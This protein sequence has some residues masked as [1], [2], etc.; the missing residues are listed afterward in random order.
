MKTSNNDSK[1]QNG[2]KNNSRSKIRSVSTLQILGHIWLSWVHL[3]RLRSARDEKNKTHDPFEISRSRN[4]PETC[5]LG[6]RKV[7]TKLLSY[8]ARG[9]NNSSTLA[10]FASPYHGAHSRHSQKKKKRRR[11]LPAAFRD[12]GKPYMH[13]CVRGPQHTP[14]ARLFYHFAR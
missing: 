1:H 2:H 13:M 9:S 10:W 6:Q 7:R 12:S 8:S 5:L 4:S 3:L 14:S 11:N